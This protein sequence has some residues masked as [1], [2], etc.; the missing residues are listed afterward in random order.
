MIVTGKFSQPAVGKFSQES[1]GNSGSGTDVPIKR[2]FV[3][4]ASTA[5]IPGTYNNG[6]AGVGA[7]FMSGLPGQFIL[8][9][10]NVMTGAAYLIKDQDTS[11]QNGIYICTNPGS[12]GVQALFTRATYYDQPSQILLGDLIAC[13]TGVIN[14]GFVFTE[15]MIVN[16]IGVD[17]INYVVWGS[18]TLTYVNSINLMSGSIIVRSPGSTLN[19]SAGGGF[20][21]LDVASIYGV[22]NP[23]IT[24]LSGVTSLNVL[25]GYYKAIGK[26]VGALITCTLLLLIETDASGSLVDLQIPVP[27]TANFTDSLQAWLLGINVRDIRYLNTS[28][29]NGAGSLA[30]ITANNSGIDVV[31]PAL[32]MAEINQT[33]R[34]YLT[35]EYQIQPT[36]KGIR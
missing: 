35:F 16:T 31:L 13:N 17:H 28:G 12:T 24:T 15:N 22:F 32:E 4:G 25:S 30:N 7:T 36:F 11:A 34:V 20:V 1:R 5:T 29:G 3:Q 8:D 27:L 33:Y 18:E 23:T 26:G 21:N 2:F 19:V 14:A 6:S 10:N 9:G